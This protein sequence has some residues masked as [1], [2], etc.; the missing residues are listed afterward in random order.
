MYRNYVSITVNLFVVPLLG[1]VRV[2]AITVAQAPAGWLKV[3]PAPAQPDGLL[4]AHYMCLVTFNSLE[5]VT[6]CVE[7]HV[8]HADPHANAINLIFP[9]LLVIR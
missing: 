6:Q 8:C 2:R 9:K 7:V 5:D 3:A 1:T 4:T